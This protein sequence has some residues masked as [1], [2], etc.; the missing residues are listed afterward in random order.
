MDEFHKVLRDS[1][2]CRVFSMEELLESGDAV[3]ESCIDPS[4]KPLDRMARAGFARALA[5]A[6]A[7][8][9]ERERW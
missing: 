2:C 3:L 6:I 4:A 1:H 8:L 5:E 9:P 7:G